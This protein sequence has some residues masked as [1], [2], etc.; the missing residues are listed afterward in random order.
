MTTWQIFPNLYNRVVMSRF[1]YHL[2]DLAFKSNTLFLYFSLLVIRKVSAEGWMPLWKL[3]CFRTKA[4]M[5]VLKLIKYVFYSVYGCR[6]Y[7]AIP[8]LRGGPSAVIDGVLVYSNWKVRPNS[9]GHVCLSIWPF[10]QPFGVAQINKDRDQTHPFLVLY[11]F[12]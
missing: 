7:D 4:H 2:N 5:K 6:V 12:L 11:H 8:F 3:T 1:I 10:G 9:M